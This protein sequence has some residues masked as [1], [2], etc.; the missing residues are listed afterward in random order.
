MQSRDFCYWLQG[1]IELGRVSSL[2]EGQMVTLRKHLDMVFVHEI[3]PSM[4]DE[5][6]RADVRAAH[7]GAPAAV[8]PTVS[9][10][11]DGGLEVHTSGSI[12][13]PKIMC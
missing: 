13:L 7:E 6:H 8:V 11:A 3:D 10:R 1:A 9:R 2:D 5:G 4:G 12:A